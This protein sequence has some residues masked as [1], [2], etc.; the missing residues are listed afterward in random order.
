MPLSSL[1]LT[2]F[3]EAMRRKSDLDKAGITGFIKDQKRVSKEMGVL[4]K[5]KK[6]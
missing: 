2:L 3:L 5:K 6:R 1:L 4:A